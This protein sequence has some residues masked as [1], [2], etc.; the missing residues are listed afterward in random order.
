MTADTLLTVNAGSSTIKLA[1]FSIAG[2]TVTHRLGAV[3]DLLRD[4]LA[5]RIR[6]G[7]ARHD[8]SLDLPATADAPAIMAAVLRCLAD[9][10]DLSGL[11]A[12]AHRVVHGGD[13][14]P[15]PVRLDTEAIAGIEA[16]TRLA[17]LHQPQNLALIRA[18]AGLRPDLLQVASFDTAFH[19]SMPEVTRRFAL[20]R[21]WFDRG[22]KRYG[23]HGL[24]YKYIAGVLARELLDAHRAVVAHLGSGASLCAM[25]GGASHD[26]SMGFSTL[27][28]VPMATRCGALDPGVILHMLAHEGQAHA[29]ISAMLY[30]R[31][32]LLGLSG[33]SGDSRV[34]LESSAA[35]AAE[36]LE[37]F[38]LR[39]AGEIARLAA[40]LSGLDVLVFTAGVGENQPWVRQA[41]CSR[42]AW[43]GITLDSKANEA[44]ARQ[45][46][47]PGSRIVVSV[48]PTDEEQIMAEE[49]LAVLDD[50]AS[51]DS[52]YEC[53]AP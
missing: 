26:T 48:I 12:V 42:L 52:L 7:G 49:S 21:E 19:G 29:D 34:L 41:V 28:G 18:V 35:E 32:G 1:L 20:P 22:V 46:S 50:R 11:C 14:F 8:H 51:S 44:N 17:P 47:A 31:S 13:L 24:S 23:F 15:G 38:A 5:L 2:Q 36:A 25:E 6:R 27:D 39:I 30:H 43:M 40:S 10:A 9:H 16:L 4:P 33:I 53:H 37:H 3:V 45:I